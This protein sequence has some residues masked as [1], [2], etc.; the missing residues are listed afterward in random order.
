VV[1]AVKLLRPHLYGRSFSIVTDHAALKW[2][3]T[4]PNLAG[5]LHRWSL[6]LQ[7]YDFVIEYRPGA[8]NVVADAL[9]RAPATVR[10]VTGRERVLVMA[11]EAD[12]KTEDDDPLTSPVV[13]SPVSMEAEQLAA[14]PES[15]AL[16]GGRTRIASEAAGP[17][18]RDANRRLE[19]E[20]TKAARTEQNDG[21]ETE[22]ATISAVPA[23]VVTTQN[24]EPPPKRTRTAR[25]MA[26]AGGALA[27]S[28]P[29]LREPMRRTVERRP[30]V[31]PEVRA[32]PRTDNE[33]DDERDELPVHELGLQLTEDMIEAAQNRIKLVQ[34]LL[35]AGQWRDRL[36]KKS[37]SWR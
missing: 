13:Q 31:Q 27:P 1:W 21:M 11:T 30:V 16:P 34:K 5:R 12:G 3:M 36:V 8:T 32:M 23:P 25:R 29:R 28:V 24:P 26:G 6:T 37:L 9:S 14:V 15:V 2:L 10:A 35:A 18:T 20:A 4:R 17:L 19:T 7:E 22:S 33:E